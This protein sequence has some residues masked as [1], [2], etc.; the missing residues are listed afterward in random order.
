[1]VVRDRNED[2]TAQHHRHHH[3][4]LWIYVDVK[5]NAQDKH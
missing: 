2:Y 1:M 4:Q 3:H 5:P